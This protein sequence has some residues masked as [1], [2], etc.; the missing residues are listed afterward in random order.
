MSPLQRAERGRW[1]TTVLCT[2]LL[3]V[4]LGLIAVFAHAQVSPT[5]PPLTSS[6]QA[7]GEAATPT[8]PGGPAAPAPTS[9][10]GAPSTTPA[11]PSAKPRAVAT[12]ASI[13]ISAIGVKSRINPTGEDSTGAIRAPVRGPKYDETAWFTGS[14]RPGQSGPAVIVG[15]VD[16][17]GGRTSVFFRLGSLRHGD[18]VTVT[19]ADNST[20]TFEV[21]RVARYAKSDFPT[22]AVYGNTDG[23]ELRLIT[24]GGQFDKA[25]GHYRD[26]TV[27]Y[28]RVVAAG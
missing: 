12:P 18:R 7:A 13:N 19:R 25:V 4:G 14:P 24:C 3:T 28:A 15:H 1:L 20:V 26:N 27:A 21:Y 17:S 22:V 10:I 23:P 9:Q 5:E 11:K 8:V 6:Q 16:G 2:L